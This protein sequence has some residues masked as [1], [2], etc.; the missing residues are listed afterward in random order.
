MLPRTKRK[1]R[2]RAKKHGF[3]A[4]KNEMKRAGKNGISLVLK[5]RMRKG[6]ERLV[7][8]A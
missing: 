2:A 7:V 6:R 3:F 5:R 8:V 1:N 4:R